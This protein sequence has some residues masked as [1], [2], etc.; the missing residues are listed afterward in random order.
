M[1]IT[2]DLKPQPFSKSGGDSSEQKILY[3]VSGTGD[4]DEAYNALVAEAPLRLGPMY[5]HLYTVEPLSDISW[6]GTVTYQ[7]N[8][9]TDEPVFS[10]EIGTAN[11][12]I[13]QSLQT[14]GSYALPGQTPPDFK[15]AINVTKDG[16]DGVDIV[17]PSFSWSERHLIPSSRVNRDYLDTL[18]FAT[19]C[20]ND[21]TF[22][23]YD[24]GE[25]LFMGC[26]LAQSRDQDGWEGNF[27]W[28]G[29]RNASNLLVG[30]I[31][32]T[33]KLGHDYL[34]VLYDEQTTP[35]GRTRKL[36]KS[37]FVERVYQFTSMDDLRLDDPT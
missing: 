8:K 9:P 29:S 31:T 28:V 10:I 19:G 14:V 2:V 11:T 37:V 32:V 36:P 22:R 5:P 7:V 30:G 3:V 6:D 1:A 25:I 33:E 27:R 26:T 17:L 21:D 23:Q 18:F 12:K 4:Q 16:V 35:D 34:W 15:G 20:M 13:T 24:R